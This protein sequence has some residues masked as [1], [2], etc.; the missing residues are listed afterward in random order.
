LVKVSF[1]SPFINGH[2]T[3]TSPRYRSIE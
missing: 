2:T 1:F 3:S